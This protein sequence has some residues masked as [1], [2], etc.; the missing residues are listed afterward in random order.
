MA[1]L[2]Y[3][4][5]DK[6]SPEAREMIG[7]LPAPF[8]IFRM[9]A[10]ADTLLKPIMKLGGTMLGKM[11]LDP[12]L[13]E[14]ALLHAVKIEGGDYEWVQHVPVA[15]QLGA[16]QAQIDALEEG[17]DDDACFDAKEKAMLRFTREVVEM[18][19]ASPEALADVRKYFSDREVVELILM[20]GFYI[21]LA[22]LTETT[23]VE[24]DPPQATEMVANIEARVAAS[25]AKQT[26]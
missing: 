5:L 22:R 25:K 13:R 26:R 18:V 20:S 10:H 4:D 14:L 19:K 15:L 24:N 7:R 2:P 6:I 8:N 17:R 3:P 12:R 16:T 21:M 23:G 1:L 9:V 11:E